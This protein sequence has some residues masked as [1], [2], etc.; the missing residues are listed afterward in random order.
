MRDIN[1]QNKELFNNYIIGAEEELFYLY[2][3]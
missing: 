2:I 3:V 1:E